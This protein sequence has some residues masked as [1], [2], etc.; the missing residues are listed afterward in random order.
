M[1]NSNP[2]THTKIRLAIRHGEGNKSIIRRARGRLQTSDM[3]LFENQIIG[4]P[5]SIDREKLLTILEQF[6]QIE[7]K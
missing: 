5:E 2:M 7:L 4:D 3:A 1:E 6:F